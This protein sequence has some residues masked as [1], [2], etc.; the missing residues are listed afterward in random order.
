MERI[1]I[2]LEAV[3]AVLLH[4]SPGEK[5]RWRAAPFRG[6]TRWWFRAVVG[7][8]QPPQEVRKQ[9]QALFGTAEAASPI[10]FR[11]LPHGDPSKDIVDTEIN[12]GVEKRSGQTKGFK[13]GSR[14]TLEL[15]SAPWVKGDDAR[16]T[17]RSTYAAVWTAVHFGGIGQR[18][19]RGAGS[20]RMCAVE[21]LPDGLP[22]PVEATAPH[23]YAAALKAGLAQV[24]RVLGASELRAFKPAQTTLR[25]AEFPV[26]HPNTAVSQVSFANEWKS[27]R[28]DDASQPVRRALMTLRRDGRWHQSQRQ[29]VEFGAVRPSRVASPLWIRIAD[30]SAAGSLVVATLLRHDGARGARWERVT[31]FLNALTGPVEVNLGGR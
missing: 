24:R 4:V 15:L 13:P 16:N 14:V 17:V 28:R 27:D 20:L 25:Q 12:P 31:E 3:T 30:S 9:E 11:V 18:C 10:V 29:E 5:P 26:L 6:L 23:A 19:R 7:A 22:G 21:R 1:T 8:A 2:E